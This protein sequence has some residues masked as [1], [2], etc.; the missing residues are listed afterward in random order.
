MGD[1]DDQAEVRFDHL[2]AGSLIA[3]FDTTGELDFLFLREE[4]SHSDFPKVNL[5]P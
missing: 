5:Y 4:G 2:L 3:L 1:F